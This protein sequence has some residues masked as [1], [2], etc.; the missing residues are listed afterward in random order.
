MYGLHKK[1]AKHANKYCKYRD[2]MSAVRFVAN[3]ESQV[4]WMLNWERAR[5]G[6]MM[7]GT[8]ESEVTCM[9]NWEPQNVLRSAIHKYV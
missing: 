8:C 3:C 1:S 6:V 7:N 2:E 5:W 4:S 9:L